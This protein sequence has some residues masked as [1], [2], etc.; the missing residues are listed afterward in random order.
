MLDSNGNPVDLNGL[1]ENSTSTT[2]S[3]I[4][5]APIKRRQGGIPIIDVRF[6][7]ERTVEMMVDTG[8]SATLLSPE[9]AQQLGVK[10]EGTFLANTPSDREVEFPAGRVES[11]TAGGA[12]ARDV[13]V[14]ISPA[15]SMGL[16]GQ[17]FFS[18]YDVVIKE[19]VVEFHD[20]E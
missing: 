17:N 11:I 15:L 20:R 13:V 16:L 1:C 14:V 8:A 9:V 5:R 10:Q 4:F 2:T 19:D 12:T 6:N 3:G 18:R 7:N